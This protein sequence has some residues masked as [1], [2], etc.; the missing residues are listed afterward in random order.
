MTDNQSS[1][2]IEEVYAALRK[3]VEQLY[4]NQL[5]SKPVPPPK[6][7]TKKYI[8]P[9]TFAVVDRP[10]TRRYMVVIRVYDKDANKTFNHTIFGR[11]ENE[12]DIVLSV[13]RDIARE[14]PNWNIEDIFAM[15]SVMP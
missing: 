5:S 2:P 11:Y 9:S 7:P 1:K 4:I 6:P 14:H 10:A 13:T 8:D 15:P 3:Q 12:K